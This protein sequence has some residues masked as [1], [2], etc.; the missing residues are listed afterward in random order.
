MEAASSFRFDQEASSAAGSVRSVNRAQA[1]PAMTPFLGMA[2]SPLLLAMP[3]AGLS[4]PVRH[5][6]P[7][8]YG[9]TAPN[10]A[11]RGARKRNRAPTVGR[12]PQAGGGGGNSGYRA[13]PHQQ[14]GAW[15]PEEDEVL[16]EMVGR[17][18]D[19]KWAF[20]A[21]YLPGRIGKQLRERWTN[22]LRPNITKNS[23]WT[24]EDDLALIKA[25]GDCGNRWSL[26]AKRLPGRSE[27]AVKNHWNATK[28]SLK[29]KRRLKKRNS[30]VPPGEFSVLERYIRMKEEEEKEKAAAQQQ[31][32]PPPPPPVSPPS[33][34][35]G[36]GEVV[37]PPPA[38][39]APAPAAG[40]DPAWMGMYLNINNAN[41][42]AA[43]APSSLGTANLTMQLL[44][45]LNAYHGG[46]QPPQAAAAQPWMTAAAQDRQ[47]SYD[48]LMTY[49]F[50]DNNFM[51]QSSFL[52]NANAGNRYY[53]GDAAGPSGSGGALDDGDVVQMAS[54]EFLMPSEDEVTLNLAGFM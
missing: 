32:P 7:T 21:Q 37:S 35:T 6:A 3:P 30:Q 10:A 48:D 31:P 15:T 9:G 13:P 49:P 53:G 43:A 23:I 36:F 34:D 14:R 54:R 39:A 44:L 8:G 24:E 28:R 41:A 20:I 5:P 45:G 19:R 1:F 2:A 51:W 38:A 4:M 26:I 29:A 16:K 46:A 33:Q 12:P 52:A 40:F 50:V 27:N 22:H 42:P 11:P 47:A 17:H 18:G 25:H